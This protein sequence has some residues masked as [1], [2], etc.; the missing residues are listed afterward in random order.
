MMKLPAI[1]LLSALPLAA[2][3][4]DPEPAAP[5]QNATPAARPASSKPAPPAGQSNF[6]GKDMPFFDPGSEILSWDGKNWNVNNNRLFQARFE[7]YLNAEEDTDEQSA[8]YREILSTILAKLA[9]G[10]SG[11]AELDEAFRLLPKASNYEIDANLCDALADAVY[12]V[13]MSKKENNRIAQAN[14]N[15]EKELK[16]HEWNAKM[17]V[18][19]PAANLAPKEPNAAAEWA[20]EQQLL[21]DMRTQPYVTRALEVRA[22]LTANKLKR[23][24]SE[25]QIKLEF[26]SLLVQFFLQRRFQ[27][28]V[29]GTRFY[30]NLFGDGDTL[31]R[32]GDDAKDLFAKSTGMPPTVGVLDSLANEAMRDAKEGV[33]AY[34]FLL[35]K[36]ELESATKRLA[37]AFVIGEYLPEL[38][39]LPREDKRQA[40]RFTQITN[41]LLSAI[42]VKDYTLAEKLVGELS[43]IAK[44]FDNSKPLAIIE[45]AKT[46]SAMHLAKAK[47]AAVSGD[48]ATLEEE[49]RTATELWP[50]NP[51]LGEVAELIFSQADVQQKA[52]VDFDQLLSQKN[53][54]QIF[55]DRM[56][57]IAATALFPDRQEALQKVLESMQSIEAAIIRSTEIAKRGDYA[58]AWENI[59]RVY[60][61]YPEDNRL[62]QVRADLTTNASDFVRTLR[63]AEEKEQR[64]QIGSSLAWY[65]KA[66]HLYAGS[67]FAR[68]GIDRLVKSI[69]PGS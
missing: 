36:N 23:E 18:S 57:F 45:T 48:R 9:P 43:E 16:V 29:I 11:P 10:R 67:E 21:R 19:D 33:Q 40:L 44:D 51:A 8:A 37:E 50:R 22:L 5:A 31:L 12:T 20:K 62:N 39:T 66:Q 60:K 7:K 2:Q 15:L 35:D 54:R 58:G 1:L 17:S 47:N 13:W 28:V 61:E 41:Q 24:V 64:G 59:E 6:L 53:F 69:M 65:L 32:V 63:A 25:I 42:E 38:R 46:V 27:H 49:L 26:Q 4:P 30:R 3:M 56:R 52:L 34:K 68:E 14:R 55:D